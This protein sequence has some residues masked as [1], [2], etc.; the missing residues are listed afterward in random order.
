MTCT[1]RALGKKEEEDLA[2]SE[3]PPRCPPSTNTTTAP[4]TLPVGVVSW[5][6]VEGDRRGGVPAVWLL[7]CNEGLLSR[8][9]T[10]FDKQI[11]LRAIRHV[12]WSKRLWKIIARDQRLRNSLTAQELG[13]VLSLSNGREGRT[14]TRP[15]TIPGMEI[16]KQ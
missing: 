10:K 7:L 16:T 3:P 2:M 9:D 12:P 13:G 6:K 1:L 8:G 14:Q 15:S 5:A 11:Q 4:P